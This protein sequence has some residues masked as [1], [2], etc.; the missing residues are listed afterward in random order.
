[1]G[2]PK[3]C[4]PVGASGASSQGGGG[5]RL[6]KDLSTYPRPACQPVSVP[7]SARI[8]GLGVFVGGGDGAQVCPPYRG[9][10]LQRKS[11]APG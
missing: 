10:A 3:A 8:R 11:G 9:R 1:M 6:T 2:R 4:P 5:G 7:L